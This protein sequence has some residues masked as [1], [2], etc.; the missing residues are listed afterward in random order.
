VTVIIS[1]REDRGWLQEA[2]DSVPKWVQV[3]LKQGTTG[4]SVDFNRGLKEATGDYIKYL[5]EDDMITPEGIENAVKTIQIQNVDFIH[6]D[7]YE[8]SES[9]GKKVYWTPRIKT[10][11][12]SDLLKKNTI[13]SASMMYRKEVFEK[14]GGFKEGL[15]SSEDYEFN[16]RCLKA[17]LKIGYCNKPLAIYRRHAAQKVR[18]TP[19]TIQRSTRETIKNEYK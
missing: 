5:H 10:P 15:D 1:Y 3:I 6:G 18:I 16:L 12:L 8:L 2:I 19:T 11:L 4:F 14:V 13:H 17:G 9:T 7:V